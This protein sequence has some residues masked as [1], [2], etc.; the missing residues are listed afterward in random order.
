MWIFGGDSIVFVSFARRARSFVFGRVGEDV[1]YVGV[2]YLG[3]VGIGRCVGWC[4]YGRGVGV[5]LDKLW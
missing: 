2:D 5:V 4:G 1:F 3:V